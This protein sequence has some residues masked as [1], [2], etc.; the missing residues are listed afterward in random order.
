MRTRVTGILLTL[1]LTTAV[2]AQWESWRGPQQNGVST[3]T[4]FV[5]SWKIDGQNHL[6]SQPVP[7]R[8]TPVVH[9]GL[10]FVL[11]R[12]SEGVTSHE[13]L[14]AFDADTGEIVW[15]DQFNVF[16]SS[17]AQP[18]GSLKGRGGV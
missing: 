2:Q 5:K 6:W 14:V 16:H 11:T 10:V 4:G 15:R 13:Q 12:G 18:T 9:Q 1:S 17:G 3:E 8:S 7:G